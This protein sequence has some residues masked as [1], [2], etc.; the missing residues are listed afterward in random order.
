[1]VVV[2]IKMVVVDIKMVDIL[3]SNNVLDYFSSREK[4]SKPNSPVLINH[5]QKAQYQK[6][7]NR[8]LGL[9]NTGYNW[10]K[11]PKNNMP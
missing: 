2:D 8:K 1:M 7:L 4:I 3:M 5:L 9:L 11:N 6:C 10:Q